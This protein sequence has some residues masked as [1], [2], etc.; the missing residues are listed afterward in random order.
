M[1]EATHDSLA[2]TGGRLLVLAAEE[3]AVPLLL[4]LLGRRALL[5]AGR[6]LLHSLRGA[7]SALLPDPVPRV[8]GSLAG[9]WM[10]AQRFRAAYKLGPHRERD[11]ER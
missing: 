4:E 11:A 3:E 5:G 10:N 6:H 8:S 1:V 7:R 2:V 9:R